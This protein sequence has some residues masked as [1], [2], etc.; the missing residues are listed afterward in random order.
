LEIPRVKLGNKN[1]EEVVASHFLGWRIKR[2][3][4][5]SLKLR[6]G[7]ERMGRGEEKRKNLDQEVGRK[8][9]VWEGENLWF[10]IPRRIV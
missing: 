10:A 6:G 5:F 4:A 7:N 2:K 8:S 1:R 3:R 9:K